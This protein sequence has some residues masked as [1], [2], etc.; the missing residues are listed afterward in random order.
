MSCAVAF[1]STLVMLC[2]YLLQQVHWLLS[3][4]DLKFLL[5]HKLLSLSLIILFNLLLSLHCFAEFIT[6]G[7]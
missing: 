5:F 2:T 6:P 4:K 7:R 3:D 1:F